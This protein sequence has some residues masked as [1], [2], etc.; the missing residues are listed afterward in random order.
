MPNQ[1]KWDNLFLKMAL[2]VSTMSKDPST[3]VGSILVTSDNKQI[4][5]GYNGFVAGIVETSEMWNNRDLKLLHVLHSEENNL[6][7]CKF[8]TK[9]TTIY[10]THQPCPKCI[11]KL[12]QAKIRRIV[13]INKY[14]KMGNLDIWNEYAK[15]F[16]EVKQMNIKGN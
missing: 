12:A 6:L 1:E 5:F 14:E 8:D 11:I 13:Y 7:N 10:V 16:D 4:S 3:R 15:L 9:G 2:E